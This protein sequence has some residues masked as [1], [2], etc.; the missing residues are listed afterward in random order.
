VRIGIDARE[1]G[2]RATGVGRYLSGLLSAWRELPEMRQH[3]LVLFSPAPQPLRFTGHVR[4]QFVAVPGSGDA[5]WE[6]IDLASAANH[7]A[8]DVFF[9]PGYT[10]PLRVGAPLVVTIHDVSF[11]AH[12]EWFGWREGTRRRTLTRLSA[13]KARTILTVSD[14]SRKEIVAHLGV[15]PAIV[16]RVYNGVTPPADAR[17]DEPSARELLVL[18]AGTI[19]NR[20]HVPALVRAFRH[21]ADRHPDASLAIVGDNR[22]HPR[23][24]V[25]AVVREAGVTGRVAI[26][27]YANDAL[28]ANLYRRARVFVFLSEYEGFGLTPLEAL[29]AGVPPVVLDT[30][31]A[32]EVCLGAAVY[33]SA[34]SETQVAAAI[35]RLLVDEPARLSI[36]AQAPPVLSRYTW[37]G[38][39]R[40]TL[41]ALVGAAR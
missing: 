24:D 21:V 12:P 6:Q 8:L 39:G 34:T 4:V 13:R 7:H 14:F 31:V 2:G 11:V 18:Y 3:E 17:R 33:V 41:D 27:D 10:A 26:H 29:S 23:L 25:A 19:F 5:W 32:R 22:S 38:A 1:L 16:R 30:P 40:E 36:L 28:L 15:D 35:E 37:A 9:A 20:R